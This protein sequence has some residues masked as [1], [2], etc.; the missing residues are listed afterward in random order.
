MT[1]AEFQA[2]I[3]TLQAQVDAFSVDF[4]GSSTSLINGAARAMSDVA[5]SANQFVVGVEASATDKAAVAHAS[6]LEALARSLA[7]AKNA[8]RSMTAKKF[9]LIDQGILT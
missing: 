2:V 8:V 5:S 7:E 1:A 3:D 4:S 6:A 9:S